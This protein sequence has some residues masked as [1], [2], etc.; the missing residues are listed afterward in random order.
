[1]SEPASPTVVERDNITV[2]RRV[3]LLGSVVVNTVALA[4]TIG[5]AA[6]GVVTVLANVA[7]AAIR[8]GEEVEL[9]EKQHAHEREL[10][11]GDRLYDQRV[12]VYEAM[13]RVVN[14]ML[15]YVEARSP[16]LTYNVEPDLP[17]EPTLYEQR[18]LHVKL[19]TYGSTAASHA[20]VDFVK[21]VRLFHIHATAYERTKDLPTALAST[22]IDMENARTAV[23][24]AAE[25][26][27]DLASDE[28]GSL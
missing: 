22:G 14:R 4:A 20:Y 11:R 17:P 15:E 16:M 5:G 2:P 1:M 28:A 8:R 6:V 3:R 9:A 27:Q 24:A 12:P 19:A 21:K 18:E 10:A 25:T 7:L 23:R 13:N 26:L